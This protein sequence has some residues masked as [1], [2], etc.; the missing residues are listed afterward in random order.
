M[1]HLIDIQ[2]IHT[3]ADLA[4]LAD[5]WDQL[6][7]DCG[8]REF[9][10]SF[11]WFH[12]VLH[13]AQDSPE[14]LYVITVRSDGELIGLLPGCIT[15]R[16]LRLFTH[17]SL[18]LIGNIYS[19]V[20]G[21]LVAPGHEHDVAEALVRFLLRDRPG[22]WAV[23]NFEGLSEND[24]FMAKVDLRLREAG[25]R[26]RS[27]PQFKNVV[28]D[29]SGFDDS[30]TYFKSLSKSLRQTVRT[31]INR[32][33]CEGDAEITL[34]LNKNQD[35]DRAMQGYYAIYRESWKKQEGDPEFHRRLACY[36]ATKG[37]LRL[38]ILYFKPGAQ[39]D[40]EREHRVASYESP[41]QPDRA[42]PADYLP[43]ASCYFITYGKTAY[44]LKTAYRDEFKKYSTGNVLFWFAVKYLLDVDGVT[45]IDHQKGDEPYK[46]RWGEIRE[47]RVQYQAANPR[48]AKARLELW[49]ERQVVPKLRRAR[50]WLRRRPTGAK[51]QH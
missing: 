7:A 51:E 46:L 10:L 39:A 45:M 12:A 5:D 13:L 27:V 38:F 15:A 30:T 18:E 50:N 8:E 48:A 21:C 41:V 34:I 1:P 49:A 17:R 47:N 28:T 25:V 44:F 33:N 29:L 43:V 35:I 24:P 3:R 19:P 9:Y 26:T 31:G 40:P 32:M 14:Y 6:A 22:K 42:V 37:R 23:L 2:V 36:L 16:K 20:R 11:D 4:A